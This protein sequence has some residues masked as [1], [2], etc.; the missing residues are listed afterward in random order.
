LITN[1]ESTLG[2]DIKFAH[3]FVVVVF[4]L[5]HFSSPLSSLLSP[6][7]KGKVRRVR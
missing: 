5:I 2:S 6:E 1:K 7:G 4:I 3:N